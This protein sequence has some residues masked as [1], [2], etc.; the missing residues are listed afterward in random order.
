M[1]S[2][3]INGWKSKQQGLKKRL[4]KPRNGCYHLFVISITGD[5]ILMQIFLFAIERLLCVSTVDARSRRGRASG[6]RRFFLQAAPSASRKNVQSGH[7]VRI[8]LL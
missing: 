8:Q 5:C 1:V 4:A 2:P 7:R 3:A 6:A